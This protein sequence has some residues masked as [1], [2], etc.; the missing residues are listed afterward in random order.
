MIDIKF[1]KRMF[2]AVV[3]GFKTTTR[4]PLKADLQFPPH[5][6]RWEPV[7]G[8]RLGSGK[9]SL[10]GFI[11]PITRDIEMESSFIPRLVHSQRFKATAVPA[12]PTDNRRALLDVTRVVIERLQGITNDDCIR[13]GCRFDGMHYKGSEHP[14][15]GTLKVFP[16]PRQA[17]EDLWRSIYDGGDKKYAKWENNPWVWVYDF[18]VISTVVVSNNKTKEN[19]YV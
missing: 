8:V 10:W 9:D 12:D 7:E 4:R 17:F 6:G 19:P 11:T 1:N 15:K 5:V 16:S 14:I 13:E 2:D 3:T 18:K